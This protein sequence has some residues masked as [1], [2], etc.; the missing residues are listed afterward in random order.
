[1]VRTRGGAQKR[2]RQQL[3]PRKSPS[4]VSAPAPLSPFQAPDF[5][6]LDFPDLDPLTPL[7]P[8]PTPRPSGP[9]GPSGPST[10]TPLA[11]DFFPS[12]RSRARSRARSGSRSSSGSSKSGSAR[13]NRSRSGSARSNRSR[14]SSAR[15]GS[16]RSNRS[17]NPTPPRT[18]TGVRRG[19]A[20]RQ[21]LL[22][23]SPNFGPIR[24]QKKPGQ[25]ITVTETRTVTTVKKGQP[26]KVNRT[27][28]RHSF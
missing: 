18:P 10:S 20:R 22:T 12:V 1:M 21:L 27:S 9:S 11:T 24:G 19:G 16:V 17:N 15:S 6:S 7:P 23:N 5:S 13:S 2:P 4:R 14:S 28:R 25:R 8:T 26:P 3:A